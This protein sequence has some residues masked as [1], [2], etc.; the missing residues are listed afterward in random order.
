MSEEEEIAPE[1]Q[2]RLDGPKDKY[3]I[4]PENYI[5]KFVKDAD[6]PTNLLKFQ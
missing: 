4:Y 6:L 1:F 2:K 5:E 3:F